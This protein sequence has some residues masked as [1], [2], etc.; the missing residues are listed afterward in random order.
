MTGAPLKQGTGKELKKLFAMLAGSMGETLGSLVSKPIVVRPGEIAV[1]DVE[2]WLNALPKASAVA[3]GALDKGY[4]GKSFATMIDVPDAIAM[5]GMLMMTPDHVI[6]Q[7]R[8]AGVLEGED[9]EAFGELPLLSATR[10]PGT[11]GHGG[12][13]I[14]VAGEVERTLVGDARASIDVATWPEGPSLVI[15]TRVAAPPRRVAWN[16]TAL[17]GTHAADC[18]LVPVEGRGTIDVEW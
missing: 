4:A 1:V 9:A 15:V 10:L 7:R 6:E 3:R 18:L 2:A 13:V 17:E 5:A 11:A 12:H 14:H 16:G 8:A